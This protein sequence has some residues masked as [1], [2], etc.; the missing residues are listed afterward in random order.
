MRTRVRTALLA[1]RHQVLREATARHLALTSGVLLLATSATVIPLGRVS[2]AGDGSSRQVLQ[3]QTQVEAV[4]ADPA[5]DAI[6]REK[7]ITSR[8]NRPGVSQVD[9]AFSPTVKPA[10]TP[11]PTATSVPPTATTLPPT[12]VPTPVPTPVPTAAPT[13]VPPP[14]QPAPAP[15]PAQPPA[16]QLRV[17]IQA[18]HWKE[19]ELPAELASL[20]GATGASGSGWREVDV[21]LNVAQRVAAMLRDSGVI[22]DILPATVPSSYKADA[23]VAIHGDANS[24]P[25]ASGYKLARATWS[26]IPQKDDSLIQAISGQYAVSTGLKLHAGSITDDMRQYYAFNWPKLVHAV[27]STT[28][29]AIIEVGFLTTSTDRRLLLEQPDRAA[30]GIAAGL[31]GFLGVR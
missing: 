4:S 6:F 22:V 14:T 15:R 7:G 18:G 31:L 19:S 16:P 12:A 1:L 20:R 21:N 24:N 30:S 17:G 8:G 10:E 5:L 2:S 23:F 11:S 29:S 25:S 26:K 13:I 9:P 27:S 3:S 28:P